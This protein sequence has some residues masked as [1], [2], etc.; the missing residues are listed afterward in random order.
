[1]SGSP[2]LERLGIRSMY[3]HLDYSK[4]LNQITRSQTV[5]LPKIALLLAGVR[6]Q[7]LDNFI[8]KRL[9]VAL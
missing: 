2:L 5:P 8:V 6:C 4:A 7:P 9:R 1:M 3:V